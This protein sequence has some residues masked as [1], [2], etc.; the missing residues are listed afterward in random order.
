M[1]P[2]LDGDPSRVGDYR[3]LARIGK[4]AMGAVYLGSSRGGRP[5]AVKV[6][7][8]ELAA[9]EEFRERFRREVRMSA[10]VGGFWTATVVD[11]DPEAPHPW[12]ATEYVPGPT[13][14]R[15]VAEH[16]P[17]PEHAVLSLGAGLAEALQAVHRAGLVHRDLKPA[18][19]LLGPD[20]PR[21]IDFGISRAMA[22]T[23]MTSTGMFFG[24]PGFFS[25]EQ[26]MGTEVGPPSDVFSLGAVLA[27]AATGSAPF[28]DENTPAMLYRVVHNEPELDGLPEKP[29]RLVA[30]CLAKDPNARPSTGEL[31]NTIGDSARPSGEWLPPDVTALI[32][33]HAAQLERVLHRSTRQLDG[34][35]AARERVDTLSPAGSG[36]PASGS[37]GAGPSPEPSPNA[38]PRRSPPEQP[39]TAEPSARP[40]PPGPPREEVRAELPGQVF[41]TAGHL[42][43]L[44]WSGFSALL[45]YGAIRLGGQ[46]HL[47]ASMRAVLALGVF[48]LVLSAVL[49]LAHAL[50]PGK[51]LKINQ[52]GIRISRMGLHRQIPWKHVGRVALVGAGKKQALAVWLVP[53]VSHDS[54]WWHRVREYRGASRIFTIGASGGWWKR[55]REA[56]RLR[57]ALRQYA[58]R[59]YD[60]RVL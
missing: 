10:A 16:G 47:T 35:P 36:P 48:L 55:R 28:G 33:G 22:S 15:A 4:G 34:S 60:S 6:A 58:P 29:R 49:S 38:A 51:K 23:G 59:R 56:R 24:T 7:K 40:S 52:D 17:F 25:P 43:A 8:P 27:F 14:H 46:L 30:A 39:P 42:S 13:L 19:V 45:A 26:T 9:D 50:L 2:L 5:V 37:A 44:L 54:R 53:G 20:G 18:N 21:V 12:L 41:R 11:A 32:T 1:Q 3:L 57:A 31:L